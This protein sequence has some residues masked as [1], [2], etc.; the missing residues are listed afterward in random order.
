LNS[1]TSGNTD[2]IAHEEV[3]ISTADCIEVKLLC[4]YRGAKY[5]D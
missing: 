3:A 1:V 4:Q 2:T 5:H